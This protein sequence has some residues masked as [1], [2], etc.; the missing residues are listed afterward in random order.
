MMEQIHVNDLAHWLKD[1]LRRPPLILDVREQWEVDTAQIKGS[2]HIPMGQIMQQFETLE[3]DQTIA[4]LCHHG[5]RSMQVGLFLERQ[6]FTVI[7]VQGGI[8][9]WSKQIDPAIS[10]Y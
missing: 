2:V 4:C 8:D 3:K 1:P 6:G 10:I 9:A 7:N 5:A